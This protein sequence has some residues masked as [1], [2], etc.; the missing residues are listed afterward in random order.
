MVLIYRSRQADF[1]IF[2]RAEGSAVEG[3][4]IIPAWGS[5][6]SFRPLKSGADLFSGTPPLPQRSGA[7]ECLQKKK[8]ET[9]S[10][11]LQSNDI[12]NSQAVCRNTTFLLFLLV[13]F[14]FRKSKMFAAHR[15]SCWGMPLEE[16]CIR[17]SLSPFSRSSPKTMPS[18]N[19]S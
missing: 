17:H 7:P 18:R 19:V 9:F 1:G 12:T 10:S 14:F 13:F 4:Y 8:E 11:T 16:V 6:R 2:T 5:T 15:R 3:S